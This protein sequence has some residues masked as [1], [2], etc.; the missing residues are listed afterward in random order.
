MVVED[1][2]E[3]MGTGISILMEK[4]DTHVKTAFTSTLVIGLVTHA[5]KFLNTLPNHDSVY[6]YYTDQNVVGSG[7]WFLTIACGFSSYFDLPWINGFLAL[8]YI[9][10]TMA[11]I[12][13]LFQIKNRIVIVLCGGGV[14][15][16]SRGDRDI[17]FWIHSGRIYACYAA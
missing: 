8:I 17:L 5:Y 4:A 3:K 7:R 12:T 1:K 9:A 10:L 15:L 6:N 13:Q 14:G 2:E 16:I 11:I